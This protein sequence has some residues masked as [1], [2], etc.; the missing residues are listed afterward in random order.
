MVVSCPD[1]IGAKFR[2]HVLS[3]LQLK[4]ESGWKVTKLAFPK[5]DEIGPLFT[6]G[7]SSM[8]LRV[9]A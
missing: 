3:V 1:G 5:P 4:D 8:R 7:K 2:F 9:N 6:A